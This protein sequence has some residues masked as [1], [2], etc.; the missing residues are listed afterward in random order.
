MYVCI[1]YCVFVYLR[2][3]ERITLHILP[4]IVFKG[5]PICEHHGLIMH[6]E[7]VRH[8]HPR[9]RRV[10]GR[11]IDRLNLSGGESH[12]Q[13]R[14]RQGAASCFRGGGVGPEPQRRL[15]RRHAYVVRI[16]AHGARQRAGELGE[17]EPRVAAPEMQRRHVVGGGGHLRRLEAPEPN[18]GLGSGFADFG[19]PLAPF[20]LAHSSVRRRSSTNMGRA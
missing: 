8:L 19:Y 3:P 2:I 20:S 12:C 11:V 17:I 9:L 16:V 10:H 4:L 13:R 5:I 18:S 1:L 6:H 15:V 14:R 7:S